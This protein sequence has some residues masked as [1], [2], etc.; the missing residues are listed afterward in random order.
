MVGGSVGGRPGRS[1]GR[2]LQ[3]HPRLGDR[4]RRMPCRSLPLISLISYQL[5]LNSRS[6]RPAHLDLLSHFH[7]RKTRRVPGFVVGETRARQTPL[8]VSAR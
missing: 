4:L 6:Y 5:L 7:L 3:Q 1:R 2:L 8:E